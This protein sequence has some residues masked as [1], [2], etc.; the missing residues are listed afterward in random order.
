MQRASSAPLPPTVYWLCAAWWLSSLLH[1]I[2]S[3][4]CLFGRDVNAPQLITGTGTV[5]LTLSASTADQSQLLGCRYLT[6]AVCRCPAVLL[7]LLCCSDGLVLVR[8]ATVISLLP[9]TCGA[10]LC[11]L[12]SLVLFQNSQPLVKTRVCVFACVC[13]KC[14]LTRFSLIVYLLIFCLRVE[15][16]LLIWSIWAKTD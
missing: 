11:V 12:L 10:A 7:L 1:L 9:A 15:F 5:T 6:A 4:F 16:L 8:S 2:S 14:N 3:P 13:F